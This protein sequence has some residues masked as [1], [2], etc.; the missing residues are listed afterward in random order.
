MGFYF[1]QQTPEPET[2]HSLISL[3]EDGCL[4]GNIARF[5]LDYTYSLSCLKAAEL[6]TNMS[7]V[8]DQS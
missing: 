2:L 8:A 6:D 3:K 7:F 5:S 4:N 1:I